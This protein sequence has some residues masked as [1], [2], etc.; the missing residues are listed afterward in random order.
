MTAADGTVTQYAYDAVDN[1]IA[2]TRAAGSALAQTTTYAYDKNNRLTATTD[3]L[4][5]TTTVEY[6]A[7]GNAVAQVDA[8][9]HRTAYVYDA[10]NR[11]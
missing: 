7:N 9:G 5:H 3:A 4:G 11:V 8:L 1:R 10:N 6:D 2:M